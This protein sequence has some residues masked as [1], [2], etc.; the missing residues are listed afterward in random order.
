MADQA[1]PDEV[2][3]PSTVVLAQLIAR[4]PRRRP[5][6]GPLRKVLNEGSP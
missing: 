1:L 3:P 2:L 4:L 5:R 6:N